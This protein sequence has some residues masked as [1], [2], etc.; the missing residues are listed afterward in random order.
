MYVG[1][2]WKLPGGAA[3]SPDN[4]S[5]RPSVARATRSTVN[6]YYTHLVHFSL[7]VSSLNFKDPYKEA[8]SYVWDK[9]LIVAPLGAQ[10]TLGNLH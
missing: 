4:P 9:I 3:I 8:K 10:E 2:Y 6:G 5:R 7:S 1:R